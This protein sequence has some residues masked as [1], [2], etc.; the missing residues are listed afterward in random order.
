MK[1]WERRLVPG[2][3]AAAGLLFL[4][5]AF[6]PSLDAQPMNATFFVLGLVFL[7]TG[8]VMWRKSSGAASPS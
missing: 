6:K 2:G 4:F 5:A 7:V 3:F 8:F 1:S